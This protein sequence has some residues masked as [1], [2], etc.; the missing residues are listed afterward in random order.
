MQ[1]QKKT[2]A[3]VGRAGSPPAGGRRAFTLIELLVVI[4]IIAI[5]AALLLPALAG[6]RER[7]RRIHC[8]SNLGQWTKAL[9]MFVDENEDFLPREG[10]HRDGHVEQDNWGN[11]QDDANGDVWYNALPAYMKIPAASNFAS[12]ASGLRPRFYDKGSVFHCPS[13]RFP[14][15]VEKDGSPFFSLT[16]NSKLI[17]P[18]IQNARCSVNFASIQ[19]PTDTAVFLE[20]RVRKDEYR[21]NDGQLNSSVGQPSTYASRFAARHARS[22]N[23]AFGDG[24]VATYKGPAVV[25]TRP[26]RRCGEAIWP[27]GPS[28]EFGQIIWRPDP[29]DDPRFPD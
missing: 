23:I 20:A 15:G 28:G 18:P 6:A 29:L 14:E 1:P 12:R 3:M 10:H 13:A 27:L 4:A 21:V 19:R 16:M 9:E 22:G 26:G 11:V 5:L 25:E 8:M 7:A 24:R 17:Q 2:V